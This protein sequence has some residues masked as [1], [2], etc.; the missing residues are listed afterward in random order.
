M[1]FSPRHDFHVPI[2]LDCMT[3]RI[4]VHVAVVYTGTSHVEISCIIQVPLNVTW[5]LI[6]FSFQYGSSNPQE[7]PFHQENLDHV[8]FQ[9]LHPT[10]SPGFLTNQPSLLA[11]PG[12]RGRLI[13][14]VFKI[15]GATRGQCGKLCF[16][17]TTYVPHFSGQPTTSAWAEVGRISED[18]LLI[19]VFLNSDGTIEIAVDGSEIRLTSY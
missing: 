16:E 19:K 11:K 3:T 5:V 10:L 17:D 12:H 14:S 18:F 15:H 13:G 8:F 6:Q 4:R 9:T 2:S 1:F 7:K